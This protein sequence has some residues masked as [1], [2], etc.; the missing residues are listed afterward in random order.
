MNTPPYDAIATFDSCVDAVADI[1][2]RAHY[3][4]NRASIEQANVNFAAASQIANWIGLPRAQHGKPHVL[5]AGT[6]S[7]LQL[8][9]LYTD[10]MVKTTGPSRDIYDNLLT[11]AG[12][13]CPLC[14]GLGQARTL[15]HYL[16]KAI[17]PAYSVHPR[18]LVP[19]CRDCNTGRNASF[20]VGFHEQ[21]LHPYFDQTR[22]FEERWVTASVQ[23]CNPILVQF[24]C[25]PPDHWPIADKGRVRSHFNS[26]K[27]A[28]RFSIQA[29]AEVSKVVQTRAKSLRSLTPDSFKDFL[30][31]NANSPDFVLN[32]WSRTT[33]AAL[34]DSDWFVQTD[35]QDPDWH[36][37]VAV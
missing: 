22:F 36:V 17:F 33:Y 23:W 5:I 37:A 10:Y 29:G 7:K 21:T 8:M 14:G 2:L 20:G 30:L 32:G 26:H 24:E 4:A 34:A 31:D 19:C 12:G 28:S 15:D 9:N 11:A 18:N 6:L 3:S 13:L 27:L 1:A 25:A 16:P 35:F